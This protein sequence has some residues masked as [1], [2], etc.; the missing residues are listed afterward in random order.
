VCSVVA[1]AVAFA[2]W[3]PLDAL[4]G[5]TLGGQLVSLVP[6]LALAVVAYLAAGRALKVREMQALLSL[7]SRLRRG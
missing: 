2:I 7:R 6:A 5:R 1:G 3:K 4:V